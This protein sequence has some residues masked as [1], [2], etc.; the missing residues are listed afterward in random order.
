MPCSTAGL[1]RPVAS[2]KQS[3]LSLAHDDAEIDRTVAAADDALPEVWRA[4]SL[5][6]AIAPHRR[7]SKCASA[8]LFPAHKMV[9]ALVALRDY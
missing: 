2:S 4:A 3:F 5:P 9:E 6:R 1:L 8:T 7:R